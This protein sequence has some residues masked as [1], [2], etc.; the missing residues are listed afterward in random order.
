[1]QI[2]KKSVQNLLMTTILENIYLENTNS[3]T[4]FY[5]S[6]TDNELHKF[7]FEIVQ[8]TNYGMSSYPTKNSSDG[9]FQIGIKQICTLTS[10][11]RFQLFLH[12]TL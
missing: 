11:F 10:V 8:F 5:A 4:P 2:G 6:S 12:N 9:T 1:M 3:K 7:Q